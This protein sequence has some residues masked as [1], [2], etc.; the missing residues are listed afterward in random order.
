MRIL[1]LYSIDNMRKTV[2]HH[3]K[4]DPQL[5]KSYEN[6]WVALTLD[7]RCVVTHGKTLTEIIATLKPSEREQVIFHKALPSNVLCAPFNAV[8]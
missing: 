3:K 6:E 1:L 8:V 5:L 2:A 7:Y 4:Y